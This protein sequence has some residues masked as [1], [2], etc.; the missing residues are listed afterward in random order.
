MKLFATALSAAPHEGHPGRPIALA[1]LSCF[2][3]LPSGQA[4]LVGF[5]PFDDPDPT[6]DASGS[7]NNL[8]SVTA[9]PTFVA[10][11]GF[12]GGAYRFNGQQRLVAG[13]DINP[14][15]LPQLTIGAWVRT[16]SLT[17]GLRKIM[18][19]DN[20]GWDRTI[21]LDD[22]EGPFRY[23]SF[24]G[25][26]PPAN[27]TPG[28]RNTTQW[29]FM[30][31]VYDNDNGQATLYVDLDAATLEAL[32]GVS[33]PTG[34]G[35]GLSNLSIGNLRSDTSDEGWIGGIDNVFVFD[36]LLS[37]EQ[38]TA[39]RNGGRNAILGLAALDPDL[40]VTGAPDLDAVPKV[41]AVKNLTFPIRNAGATKPLHITR[42]IVQGV[43]AS[44][45]TAASFPSQLNPGAVGDIVFRLDS[46]GQVGP[47]AATAT[48]ESDDPSTPKLVLDLATRVVAAQTLLGLY[49]FDDPAS[50]LKDDSGGGRTLVNGLDAGNANPTYLPSG[51]VSGGAYEFGGQQRLVAPL[52]IN[53]AVVPRLGM[54]AWVK[55]A[56]LDPGLRKV[57]G[58]DNGG[59]DRTI[60]L[61]VRSVVTGGDLP[62]GTL[63]YAAF[64]GVNN[65]GPSQGNPPPT[66]TSTEAWT[67]LAVDYDQP[68]N[69]LSLYV[70]LDVSDT[71]DDLQ[72]VEQQTLMAEG[73]NSV[74]IGGLTPTG[75]GEGWVG[76]IDTVFFVNGA[77]DL[78]TMNAIRAGGKQTLLQFG[79][80]PVLAVEPSSV[81]GALPNG[82]P[83]TVQV[84]LR[85]GGASQTL[86]LADV[87][88]VGR[89]AGNY[90]LGP[91]PTSIAPGA[92][93]SIAVTFNADGRQGAFQAALELTS[94]DSAGRRRSVDL[95]ASVPFVSLRSS[96]L[97]FYS[98]DDPENP[99]KD[100]SG[101]GADLTSVG[102]DPTYEPDT[103]FEG[104]NFV[105][106]GGQ[107][108][109]S[110]INV[111]PLDRAVVT[112]GAWVKTASLAPGLRKIIG[113]DDGGWDRT[114][115]LD[116]R[117]G[118][119]RYA[120]F[121][122]NGSP[123]VGAP[124]PENTDDWTFIAGTFDQANGVVSLY[125]DL[126]GA[127]T[128][129]ELVV[130]SRPNSFF[131][132]GFST[133]S[134]GSLRPDNTAESWVGSIDN[135][136]FYGDLL[137][138]GDLTKIRNRGKAAI[139]EA[140]IRIQRIERT[141]AG[142]V[143]TWGTEAGKTYAV[144]YA[145]SL[146]GP[147]AAVNTLT[148]TGPSATFTDTSVERS[149]RPAGFYRIVAQ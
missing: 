81:F 29:T 118:G 43:D 20:G 145:T 84:N 15:T 144:E 63:R 137:T 27:G 90:T 125:V 56:N 114:I 115:G 72:I 14:T 96:L 21:G 18:G 3:L 22:R 30:A 55:T 67:F 33:V 117:E 104:G 124:T 93:A 146:T 52:D 148:A 133:T 105:F 106:G 80:D 89:D 8:Q 45:F 69:R 61:D 42:I 74:S 128:D 97:G 129:D 2:L 82:A 48:V 138:I 62:D 95:S 64:T 7:G 9:D 136:F 65:F 109:V 31:A 23:T 39:I 37:E 53:P 6:A 135:V 113:S 83:K 16:D 107:H 76:A 102:T 131:G 142:L 34:F 120:A 68:N 60:G 41:P 79:P 99:L 149:G 91:L 12:E 26:G 92:T 88:I 13:I 110:P 86:N 98:F 28:P 134:I 122:G 147:W 36:E 51:G 38:I 44:Y 25:N 87:R 47:F 50:P 123:L 10:A 103:G 119:F 111:G 49:S 140:E 77:L 130:A 126:N 71:T 73:F 101:N 66:P 40:E 1:L 75:A 5:Y 57:L 19:S 85:N 108:L 70:D 11:G 141:Q 116:D 78:A 132:P 139:L 94:N 121:V 58:H 17:P 59:W 112:F 35:S 54:G 24:I 32:P 4:A 46:R 127:T 143:I 100:D